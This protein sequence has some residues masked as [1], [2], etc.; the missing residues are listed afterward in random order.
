MEVADDALAAREG[1]HDDGRA[2]VVLDRELNCVVGAESAI[3]A[4]PARLAPGLVAAGVERMFSKAGKLHGAD[5]APQEDGTLEHCLFA[6]A[7]TE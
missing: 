5:K 2:S 3:E 7:N 6:S 4:H 1:V